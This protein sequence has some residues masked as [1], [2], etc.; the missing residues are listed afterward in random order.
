[1]E[2]VRFE[3][4][5]EVLAGTDLPHWQKQSW[6]T[7]LR[8]Y[9][10]FCRRSRAAV[11]VETA[12]EFVAWAQE[13]KQAQAWQVVG[14]K[15]ALNWF[16][17]EARKHQ[18]SDCGTGEKSDRPTRLGD[19]NPKFGERGAGTLDGSSGT[20]LRKGKPEGGWKKD[21]LT[22]IRRRHYSYRTEQSYLVW[23]QRFAQFCRY[24]INC[25][26]SLLQVG[27]V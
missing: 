13:Q 15:E 24:L 10:S 18:G 26:P 3:Q 22:V 23:L 19:G 5:A 25:C 21:F 14:W 2:A 12:R 6:S 1:M 17:R 27:K 7:T 16:F 8:W 9:L 11:R 20:G 4:W